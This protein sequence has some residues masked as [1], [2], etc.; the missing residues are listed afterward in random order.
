MIRQN[1]RKAFE[2]NTAS[3]KFLTQRQVIL[4]CLETG[5]KTRRQIAKITGLETSAVSGRV[6]D[7]LKEGVVVESGH[8]KCSTTSKTVATVKLAETQIELFK[9]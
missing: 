9:G 6:N 3:G 1:S 2:E 7:L 5:Q 4:N 8:V